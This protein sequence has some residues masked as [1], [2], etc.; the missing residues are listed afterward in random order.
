MASFFDSLSEKHKDFIE[1]QQMFFTAT[2]CASGR[3]NLSPK[4]MDS[5]RVLG[6]NLCGYADMAGSGNETAAHIA[7]DGRLTFMFN[8]FD[9]VPLILRLYGRGRTILPQ[10]EE[11][12]QLVSV[13]PMY[14]GFRQFILMDVESVQ[15]S[16]GY[17][18]PRMDFVER[19][20]TLEKFHA[21]K[22]DEDHEK[23]LRSKGNQSID[24]FAIRVRE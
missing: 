7:N 12:D 22:T 24:G 18:V 6:P 15:E 23:Y 2:A 8:S 11:F 10:D 17:A 19:R 13:F 3:V 16:C 14:K 9:T 1:Q 21:K 20:K 4:G 5:F